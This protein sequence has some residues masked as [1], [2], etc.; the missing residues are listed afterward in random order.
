MIVSTYNILTVLERNKALKLAGYGTF[1]QIKS[2]HDTKKLAEA[3]DDVYTK[4]F[5]QGVMSTGPLAGTPVARAKEQIR[6]ALIETGEAAAYFEP[7]SP[8]VARS[9]DT[10]VCASCDQW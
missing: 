1:F 10:C 3:K 6:A 8:V 4:G 2:Q 9:G 5:H 7:M